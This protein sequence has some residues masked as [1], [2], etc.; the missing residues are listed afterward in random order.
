MGGTWLLDSG[1]ERKYNNKIQVPLRYTLR[2][3][4]YKYF[5]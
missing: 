5:V 2:F 3:I 1:D 4:I